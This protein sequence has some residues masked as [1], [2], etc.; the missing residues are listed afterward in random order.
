MEREIIMANWY[1]SGDERAKEA[2]K[3]I[4]ETIDT[5]SKNNHTPLITVLKEGYK[6]LEKPTQSPALIL[7]RLQLSISGCLMKNDIILSNESQ[8]LL[9]Q[10]SALSHIR[11]GS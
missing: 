4:S 7:S 6:E 9:S 5:L 3:L 11:Y 8:K 10:L 2:V 1:A